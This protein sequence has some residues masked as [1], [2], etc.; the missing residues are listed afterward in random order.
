LR[1]DA[2]RFAYHNIIRRL[3]C[4]RAVLLAACAF[5]VVIL[6]LE[7]SSRFRIFMHYCDAGRTKYPH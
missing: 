1:V 5:L 4:L 6:L 7:D 3:L 2:P